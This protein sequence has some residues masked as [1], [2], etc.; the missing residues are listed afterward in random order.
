[1]LL[2]WCQEKFRV[3]QWIW[4]KRGKNPTIKNLELRRKWGFPLFLGLLFFHLWEKIDPLGQP[5]IPV[6]SDHYFCTCRQSIFQN[7]TKI[8][9]KFQYLLLARLWIWPSGS[10]M[11][12][13]LCFFGYTYFLFGRKTLNCHIEGSQN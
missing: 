13:I 7:P 9:N 10:L 11:T 5:T 6:S 4:L 8:K 1:M 3:S 2:F 12:P